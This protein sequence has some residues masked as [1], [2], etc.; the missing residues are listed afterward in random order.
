MIDNIIGEG[1]FRTLESHFRLEA[2]V[3]LGLAV[4]HL[5]TRR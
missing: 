3:A 2:L 1:A 4:A 5:A